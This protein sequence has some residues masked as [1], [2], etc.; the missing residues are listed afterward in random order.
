MFSR[1]STSWLGDKKKFRKTELHASDRCTS[2]DLYG[3]PISLTFQGNDKF[4]TRVGATIT[5]LVSIFLIGFGAFRF[6]S[7]L[8]YDE[9]NN[10]QITM[11]EKNLASRSQGSADV[12]PF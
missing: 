5:I 11:H 3:K 8:R 12:S 4:K 6:Q 7:F 9:L 10:V 2:F 1:K